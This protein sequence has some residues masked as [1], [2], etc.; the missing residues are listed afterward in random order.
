MNAGFRLLIDR[1][2]RH[3]EN[4]VVLEET[5][6]THAMAIRTI[7]EMEAEEQTL[8]RTV[9]LAGR[10]TAGV[11]RLGRRWLSP[12][13]GLYLNWLAADVPETV[14]PLMPIL[15]AAAGIQALDAAGLSGAAIK[16]PNDLLVEGR[17]AGGIL[18]HGRRG[19]ATWTTIG[20]GINLVGTP[21][22]T[23][24]P[25]R[26]PT[27]VAEHLEPFEFE[28]LRAVMAEVLI[29]RLHAAILDPAP[30]VDLWRGRLIHPPGEKLTIQI[31]PD[32][33]IT[34]TFV[35]TD[36]AGHLRLDTGDGERIISSGDIVSG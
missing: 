4:I 1:L 14:V 10:Q 19:T 31:D 35:G 9:L 34:G 27:S 7:A 5:D 18:V 15:A 33:R 8:P 21:H 3:V 24:G 6:S 25:P 2:S 11:G 29:D 13:G 20:I 36:P 22:P 17:K 32:T 28:E 16:W 12:V 30:A 26:P 23:D